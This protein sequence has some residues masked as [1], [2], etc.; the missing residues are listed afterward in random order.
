MTRLRLRALFPAAV[1]AGLLALS[2]PAQ[3]QLAVYDPTNHIQNVIQAARALEQINNQIQSLQNEAASLMNQARNLESL[4]YSS[5]Q[6]LQ[7]QVERTRALLAE[8]QTLAYDVREIE[9]AFDGRYGTAPMS[10]SDRD[11]VAR[12]RDRWR[13]S[14]AGLEDAMRLQA[15]V[16]EGLGATRQELD[17]LVGASQGATGA[18][19]A[20]QAGNQLLGLQSA[21]LVELTALVAAQGR[22]DALD[23][24]DR[25]A[26]RADAQARFR[27]F[28]GDPGQ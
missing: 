11:L 15:G 17:R 25:A 8:A 12:A 21:Q 26:A 28:M 7:G 14:V 3:A 1:A 24:A 20:A 27:R 4:P 6:T 9:A 16:V 22:A 23:A 2:G 5:L 19:Q 10:A 18:L 13:S